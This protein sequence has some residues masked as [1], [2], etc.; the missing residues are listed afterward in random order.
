MGKDPLLQ[1]AGSALTNAAQM[2]AGLCH[3]GTLLAHSQ[4]GVHRDPQVPLHKATFQSFVSQ[5]VLVLGV[6]SLQMQDVAFPVD[7]LRVIPLSPVLQPVQLPLNSSRTTWCTLY[8][9]RFCVICKLAD[10]IVQILNDEVKQ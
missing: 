4:L 10:S 3:K 1:Y 2:G 9:F 8:S 6:T 7:E 5:C